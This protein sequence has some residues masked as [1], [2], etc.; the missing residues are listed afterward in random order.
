M[1]QEQQLRSLRQRRLWGFPPIRS[2][3]GLPSAGLGM[4]AWGVPFVFLGRK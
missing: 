1:H 2:V 4:C 3:L